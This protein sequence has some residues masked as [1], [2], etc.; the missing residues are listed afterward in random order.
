MGLQLDFG[1]CWRNGPAFSTLG[2]VWWGFYKWTK[3]EIQGQAVA[4]FPFP[5]A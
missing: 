1:E 2:W 5:T 3:V 4:N